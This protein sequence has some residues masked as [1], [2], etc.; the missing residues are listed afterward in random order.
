MKKLII[1]ILLVACQLNLLAE[2]AIDAYQLSRTNLNGSSRFVSMGGAFGALGGDISVLN[3]NP[4]GLGVYRSSD[5]N[6]T[7]GLDLMS[8]KADNLSTFTSSKFRIKQVGY[9]GALKLDSEVM[10]NFNWGFS[11]N[12]NSFSRRFGGTLADFGTSLSNVIAQNTNAQNLSSTDLAYRDNYN[13]YIDSNAPWMSILAYDASIIN[14]Q[15]DGRNFSGLHKN[16]TSVTG[17][18]EFE[19]V[20][21]HDEFNI[22]FGGNVLNKIYWGASIGISTISSNV[23]SYYGESLQDAL[24]NSDISGTGKLVNGDASFGLETV[25][26][27]T[28]TGCNF[29]MGAIFKPINELRLGVAFHTPTF[30]S[31]NQEYLSQINYAYRIPNQKDQTGTVYTNDEYMNLISYRLNTPWRFIGSA[32]VVLGGRAILSADY[33]YIGYDKMKMSSSRGNSY[34]D[35]NNDISRYYKGSSI[36]RVGA[37]VRA[38]N[39]LSIRAGFSTQSC[40]VTS[41]ALENR[42]EIYT[43]ST[44]PSY[45][46]DTSIKHITCGLGYKWQNI[47]LDL[48]YVYQMKDSQYHAFSVTADN[49]V[50]P[51]A[52]IKDRNNNLSLTIGAR[53]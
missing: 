29:K 28:G 42:T 52:I 5:V 32:A 33:E 18:Y 11:F 36:I 13:P 8:S 6:I 2:G 37:E 20:G 40:P 49:A 1:P 26:R 22:A 14:P 19:E 31:I 9:I 15:S 44:M 34:V 21:N 41:E 16:G 23:Y 24:V 50:S 43:T 12:R 48:A 51:M 7:F 30:Y 38:T 39:N 47:Y 35:L 10:P 45:L 25:Q 46:F 17:E 53:F 3:Q 4:G 27:T